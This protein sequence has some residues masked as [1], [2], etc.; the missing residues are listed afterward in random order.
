MS[1]V[2]SILYQKWYPRW[3]E[4]PRVLCSVGMIDLFL[5]CAIKPG[6]LYTSECLIHGQGDDWPMVGLPP[7]EHHRLTAA[8]LYINYT[9][10]RKK[11]AKMFLS[12]L[13]QNPVDS[14]KIWYT[15][16]WTN[17][18]YNSIN[19]FLITWIMSPHYLVKLSVVFCKWTA[20]GTANPKTHQMFLSHRLQN[21]P[22]LI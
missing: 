15:L 11:H 19:I 22:I 4:G 5:P 8:K 12:Y 16:S 13:L 1:I 2:M 14:D 18:R 17:L 3:C 7:T 10:N 20:I 6:G 21:R 9:V